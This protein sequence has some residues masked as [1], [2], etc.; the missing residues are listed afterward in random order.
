MIEIDYKITFQ[1]DLDAR[2]TDLEYSFNRPWVKWG[3]IRGFS[4]FLV[5]I[6]LYSI[7]S[8]IIESSDPDANLAIGVGIFGLIVGVIFPL[9]C[10]PNWL[11]LLLPVAV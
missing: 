3:V 2:E 5:L 7:I 6:G 8:G 9:F 11:N 1:D 10:N 4:L